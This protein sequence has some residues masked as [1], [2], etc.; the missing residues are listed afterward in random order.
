MEQN[1][2]TGF[3]ARRHFPKKDDTE[4]YLQQYFPHS[5]D[6][7]TAVRRLRNQVDDHLDSL[8]RTYNLNRYDV[9]AFTS[10]FHQQTAA[11]AMARLCRQHNPSVITAMGGPG[12]E[13]PYGA[14]LAKQKSSIQFFFFRPSVFNWFS[15]FYFVHPARKTRSG[16]DHSRS[17]HI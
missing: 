6:L 7:Q 13:P 15:A 10:K 4:D 17:V 1:S 3:S 12:C 14:E 11:M 16:S 5:P 2:A 9:V 8:Y